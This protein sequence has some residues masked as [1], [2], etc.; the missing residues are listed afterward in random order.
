M[1]CRF[2]SRTIL[3]IRG[4]SAASV[5]PDPVGA[6]TSTLAPSIIKGMASA[7]GGVG[8]AIP[9][10]CRSPLNG[11]ESSVKASCTVPE[12]GGLFRVWSRE[13]NFAGDEWGN[14]LVPATGLIVEPERLRVQIPPGRK[15]ENV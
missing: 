7:W 8:A 11:G 13:I 15:K 5:F 2:G 6:I 1:P 9:V 12:P 10:S 4:R 14:D 3:S